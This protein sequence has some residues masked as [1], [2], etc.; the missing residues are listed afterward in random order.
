M[1]DTV[2]VGYEDGST[3]ILERRRPRYV[4]EAMRNEDA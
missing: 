1:A 3:E 2:V 4:T